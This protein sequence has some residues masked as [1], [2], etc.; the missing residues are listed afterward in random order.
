MNT[1]PYEPSK[2]EPLV[3][4]LLEGS[5]LM[6]TSNDELRVL[7]TI[8]TPGVRDWMIA[9][10]SALLTLRALHVWPVAVAAVKTPLAMLP[11][12]LAGV[13]SP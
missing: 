11:R 3:T 5:L 9:N 8:V 6:T 13:S 7:H 1:R 10:S 12:V 4:T 2:L